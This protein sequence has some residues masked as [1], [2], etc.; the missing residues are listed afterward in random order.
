MKIRTHKLL[1]GMLSLC[2]A[3]PVTP[4]MTASAAETEITVEVPQSVQAGETFELELYVKGNQGFTSSGF[5]FEL[6]EI[7]MPKLDEKQNLIY[8]NGEGFVSLMGFFRYNPENNVM[9]YGTM[10]N[11][12]CT[13]DGMLSSISVYVP[14][15]TP[16]GSY[17]IP[18]TIDKISN[19]KRE[20]LSATAAESFVLNV[21]EAAVTTTET[22]TTEITAIET[23]TTE[24]TTV[25]TTTIESTTLETTTTETTTIET[26]TTETTTVTTQSV[27]ALRLYAEAEKACPDSQTKLKLMMDGNVGFLTIG[28][29]LTLPD[30]L[31]PQ[32]DESGKPVFTQT[33]AL[34]TLISVTYNSEKN[35]IGIDSV[36]P[37]DGK[38]IA[39][40][41]TLS[42]MVTD[43]AE[44]GKSYDIGLLLDSCSSMQKITYSSDKTAQFTASEPI[45][46]K[47]SKTEVTME[48]QKDTVQLLLTPAP[49]NA[50]VTWSSEDQNIATVD[51]NGVIHAICNG[52]TTVHAVCQGKQ[53]DCKV[54]VAVPLRLNLY[55]LWGGPGKTAQLFTMPKMSYGIQWRS[56]NTDIVTVDADGNAVLVADG[57]ASIVAELA[58]K[59]YI[60]PVYV[61]SYVPGDVD[62]NGTIDADDANLV[63]LAY[64]TT[65]VMGETTPLDAFQEL[66]ADYNQDGFLN[67]D[68][69]NAILLYYLDNMMQQ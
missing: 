37:K 6:G 46:R 29:R 16:I 55:Q 51:A 68:D 23:T 39:E 61:K 47:L 63:L 56:T 7:L 1:A 43:K 2:L 50:K 4:T 45:E 44:I 11:E 22:T 54:T 34:G 3:C 28:M 53:Y 21:A 24:T 19:S 35:V 58:G 49:E 40:L 52:T 12:D 65:S 17:E 5:T 18:F 27:P 48:S 66:A 64:L 8:Q 33:D 25:E 67:A 36:S 13:A 60:C 10:G 20:Q 69:A 62:F 32:L 59:K 26:T 14:E 9:A 30:V 15:G 57:E 31:K 41:G 42:L 38:A